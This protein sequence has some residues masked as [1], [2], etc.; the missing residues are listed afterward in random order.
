MKRTRRGSVAGLALL[1]AAAL[2]VTSCGSSTGPSPQRRLLQSGTFDQLLGVPAA[3]ALG[4]SN[5]VAFVP[6]DTNA[7]GDVEAT[8]DWSFSSDDL[9]V[10]LFRGS[11]TLQ[12]AV[13]NQ[14]QQIAR[15]SST[16][17]KP[18]RLTV[19]GLSAG[20]YTLGIA[21]F[22]DNTESGSYQIFL[23]S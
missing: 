10:V 22:G 4:F 11:C 19:G 3:T 21:N 6:F 17:T 23:T 20:S 2:G 14:C 9:D 7:P 12:Q 1:L 16:A 15:T 13:N 18:E 5:D 8:V